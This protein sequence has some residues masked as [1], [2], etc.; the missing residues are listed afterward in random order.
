MAKKLAVGPWEWILSVARGQT[1]GVAYM[2]ASTLE[3]HEELEDLGIGTSLYKGAKF[4]RQEE[5][6]HADYYSPQGP[7]C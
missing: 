3:T 5:C 1:L 2:S 6:N 4:Q 7:Y